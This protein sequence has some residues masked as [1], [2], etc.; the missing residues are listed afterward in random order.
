MH[1]FKNRVIVVDMRFVLMYF[2]FAGQECVVFLKT[3]EMF[4]FWFSLLLSLCS[5]YFH[6][7]VQ[8]FG[9]ILGWLVVLYGMNVF[10][11]SSF[12]LPVLANIL[13]WAL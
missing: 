4:F 8:C 10:L 1:C 13:F 11:I 6:M 3:L 12:H 7:C 9:N 2:L 5:V